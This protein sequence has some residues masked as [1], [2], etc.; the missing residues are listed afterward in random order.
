MDPLRDPLYRR[1][2]FPAEGIGYAVRLY[3]RFPLTCEWLGKCSPPTAL[4]SAAKAFATGRRN[5]VGNSPT[6][7]AAAHRL[8][9]TN[10]I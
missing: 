10:G 5:S 9:A 7:F 3:F 4:T 8:A 6:A 2:R 1:H